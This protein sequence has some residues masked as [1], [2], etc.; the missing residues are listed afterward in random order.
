M[1]KAILP[2]LILMSACSNGTVDVTINDP[3]TRAVYQSY[4]DKSGL[5]YEVK[6]DKF[7]IQA[8]SKEIEQKMRPFYEWE[9]NSLRANGVIVE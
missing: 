1:K 6:D 8:S 9:K 4:L 3:N 2:L 5:R 7:L